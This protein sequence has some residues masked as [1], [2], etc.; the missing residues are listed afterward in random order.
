MTSMAKHEWSLDELKHKSEAYCAY[1]EHCCSEMRL[2]LQQWEVSSE[3]ISII[4]EHLQANNYINEARYCHAFTHDKLQY[5]GWGRIKIR[6]ALHAKKLP[7]QHIQ[8]ALDSIDESDYFSA[9]KRII[10]TKKRAIRPTD[11]TAHEKLIRFC[12]Q[13]GFTYEEIKDLV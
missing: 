10:T 12:L 3:Q 8:E 5:Q 6:A 13:R 7:G 2:K 11:P 1:A 4:L 9:L